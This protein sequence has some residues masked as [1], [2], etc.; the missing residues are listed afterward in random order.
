MPAVREHHDEDPGAADAAE[1]GI[2]DRASGAEV[3]LR[4]VPGSTSIR[5]VPRA[6][7]A[8]CRRKRFTEE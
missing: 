8:S 6:A 2:E 5:T 1:L 3:D 4:F 7:G